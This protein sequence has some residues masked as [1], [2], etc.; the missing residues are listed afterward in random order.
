[1]STV[2]NPARNSLVRSM[3]SSSYRT[4]DVSY[5]GHTGGCKTNIG[6]SNIYCKMCSI[7]YNTKGRGH[8]LGILGLDFV[9]GS[10]YTFPPDPTISVRS[11]LDLTKLCNTR[12]YLIHPIRVYPTRKA[13][14]FTQL[15]VDL[16]K[17]VQLYSNMCSE[18]QTLVILYKAGFGRGEEGAGL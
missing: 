12:I 6:M 4:G 7:L 10:P 5:Q 18:L 2:Q 8:N 11:N 15:S 14:G 3:K 1:M 9:F 13:L 16:K 17:I